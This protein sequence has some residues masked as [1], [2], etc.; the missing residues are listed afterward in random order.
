VYFVTLTF[1]V[2]VLFIFYIQDVLKFK[3]QIP[4][5]KVKGEQVAVGL[6]RE[7]VRAGQM[8]QF[9]SKRNYGSRKAQQMRRALCAVRNTYL[10]SLQRY[11]RTIL[12][13]RTHKIKINEGRSNFATPTAKILFESMAFLK[14]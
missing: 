12:Q 6:V 10:T 4:V 7:K 5:P 2:P 8:F 9:I 13:W 11:T 3:C 14:S 1:L